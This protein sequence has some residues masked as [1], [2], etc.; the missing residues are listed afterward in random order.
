MRTGSLS[1]YIVD[2]NVGT[3]GPN[4]GPSVPVCSTKLNRKILCHCKF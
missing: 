2:V 1:W 3:E 4:F